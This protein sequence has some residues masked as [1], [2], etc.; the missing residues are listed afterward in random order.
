MKDFNKSE[1]TQKHEIH[2]QNVEFYLNLANFYG[3]MENS[4]TKSHQMTTSNV[5]RSIAK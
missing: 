2:N 5:M 1:T 4:S 3:K